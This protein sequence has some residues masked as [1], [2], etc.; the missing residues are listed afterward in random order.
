VTLTGA[1]GCGK[2]RLALASAVQVAPVFGGRVW[3]VDL[4]ALVAPALVPHTVAAALGICEEPGVPLVTTLAATLASQQTLLVLDNCEHLL[5]G[6]VSLVEILLRSCPQLHILTTSRETL[7]IVGERIWLVPPLTFPSYSALSDQLAQPGDLLCFEAV[8]LFL[9]RAQAVVPE[10]GPDPQV[11]PLIG[12]ICRRLDGIP[13][14]IELAA[15]RVRGLSVRQIVTR[16]DDSMTL[17]TSP[18]RT[19]AATLDWSYALLTDQ[20]RVVLRRLSVFAGGWVLEAA[21]AICRDTVLPSLNVS[22]MVS[23]LVHKSFVVIGL[24]RGE[25]RYRLLEP[26]RQY[27]GNRLRAA[28]EQP[29]IQ[30]RHLAYFAE[31]I[32]AAS[33]QL[34]GANQIAWFEQLELEFDNLRAAMDRAL[35]VA[36]ETGR[37]EAVVQALLLPANLERFWSARGHLNE[38]SERLQ[39]A[40][41]LVSAQAV[42]AASA[43]AQS[44]NAAGILAWLRGDYA[45]SRRLVD[46][47]RAIGESLHDQQIILIAQRNLGTLAVLQRDVPA[48]I[49]LLERG[50]ALERELAVADPYSAAWMV[51]V[52]GSAAYLQGDDERAGAYFEESIARFRV[53]GDANFLALAL[54]RLG[55]I[56]LRTGA[57]Q[58]ARAL[59]RESLELNNQIGSPAGT[60]ACLG[61]VAGVLLAQGQPGTAARLLGSAHTLLRGTAGQLMAADREMLDTILLQTRTLLGETFDAPWAA[62][63]AVRGKTALMN[64]V[65]DACVQDHGKMS[66]RP[67]E[68]PHPDV[69]TAREREVTM[70]VAQGYSNRE[71]AQALT[72]GVKT[73]EAHLTRILA[74]LGAASR[75]QVVLWAHERG[76]PD[77]A[78]VREG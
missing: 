72:V 22:E 33:G 48:G 11:L 63:Q 44:L 28:R 39:R 21:E 38:G 7:D 53:L 37:P 52:L 4:S 43:R 60:A 66:A 32:T 17:L 42:E 75:V 24:Q 58:R 1:G 3:F 34:T 12:E 71:I 18:R 41:T 78:W 9:E 65:A 46:E 68:R 19:M 23:G 51:T 8:Q 10:F 13:L 56:A 67:Y 2:T 29:S 77:Q 54:R 35:V 49:E 20:E 55:Q 76:Y 26:I 57:A 73:V 16:L 6:C 31:F 45:E 64:L 5:N 50:M 36:S 15:A 30:D 27:A 74:K 47:A 59:L 61:G 69:L 14:A 40:L 62:G 25:V 70:L